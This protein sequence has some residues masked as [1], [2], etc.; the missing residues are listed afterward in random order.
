MKKISIL[1][2]HKDRERVMDQLQD[3]GV[4]HLEID[5]NYRDDRVERIE[6]D[7]SRLQKVIE[8][9]R[10]CQD[11]AV[12]KQRVEEDLTVEAVTDH[13][14]DLRIQL[15]EGTQQLELVAKE[16]LL[17]RP[18][19]HFDRERLAKVRERGVE[20]HF[21]VADQRA[22]RRFDF[23]EV[24]VHIIS[25]EG[26]RTHF[27]VVSDG[28]L[29]DLPFDEIVLP[30]RSLA[31]VEAREEA[32]WG[33][34]DRLKLEIGAYQPY[35]G[36]LDAAM[37]EVAFTMTFHQANGSF[38]DHANGAICSMTGWFPASIE[39]RLEHY[40]K[41]AQI[42]FGISAPQPGDQ[43]PVLLRNARYPRLFETITNIF[44]LPSYYELDLTP[45]IAVFYP[46][47]FAYCLGDAGYGFILL[48]GAI[49]GAFTFLKG[50][51][52]L[53]VLG[54]VLGAFTMVMGI[55]KSGSLFGVPLIGSDDPMLQYLAQFVIIQDDRSFVFNAFNVALMIGVVQIF[56]GVILA[57]SNKLIYEGVS[58]AL[59]VFGKL[60]IITAA[61]C[62]FLAGN[63][64]V[65]A[66]QPYVTHLQVLAIVGIAM[67]LAFH[68]M[69]IPLGQRIPSGLLPLFFIFTGLLGDTLS[70]VR[71][72]ALGV[73]S[74]VLGLVVNQIGMQMMGDGVLSIL[75]GSVFLIFGHTL[76]LAL[77]TLGAF[78]HPLRLTFVEFYGNAQFQGGG[79]SYRP[80]R[81]RLKSI[82][83]YK[84]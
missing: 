16:K 32:L 27:V 20:V 51:R 1:T 5:Y 31:E 58:A 23:G 14:S 8:V 68:D 18:W 3:L 9:I 67:V 83:D 62:L 13:V 30:A 33:E 84:S 22:F 37:E 71:L 21:F 41:K 75:V 76:N 36:P 10:D 26:K 70:Y 11:A 53:A 15:E 74:A 4:L 64:G 79:V 34:H 52:D 47:F 69:T 65:T 48:A 28:P 6:K 77:A 56:V 80:F 42:T 7:Q 19:G 78:V 81:K 38:N 35:L 43:V 82:V 45:F 60:M 63:Q 59:P 2:F 25:Q 17:L 44:Q 55:V 39:G 12:G 54:I 72:F 46:I 73:A 40:L 66:L 50:A 24:Q 49:I 61:I 57:I 29:P